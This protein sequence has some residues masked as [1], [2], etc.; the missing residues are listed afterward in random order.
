MKKPKFQPNAKAITGPFRA[1]G[2]TR[3]RPVAHEHNLQVALVRAIRAQ[4]PDILMCASAGGLR[5]SESQAKKMKAAGYRAGFPDLGIYECRSGF[6]GLF[7][8]LKYGNNTAEPSQLEWI[9]ELTARGYRAVVCNGFDHAWDEVTSYMNEGN[10]IDGY[11]IRIIYQNQKLKDASTNNRLMV[12][13][14]VSL[15]K[16]SESIRYRHQG[17]KTLSTLELY[18]IIKSQYIQNQ[19][20]HENESTE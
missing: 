1:R 20:K 13:S 7:I 15:E 4:Y 12:C 14:L 3:K 11:T 5:T 10:T 2:N 9:R 17:D 16:G 18:R 8:E 19:I 6:H